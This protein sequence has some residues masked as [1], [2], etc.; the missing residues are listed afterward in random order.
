MRFKLLE[1]PQLITTCL[2]IL[3]EIFCEISI[4]Q[5]VE[6]VVNLSHI[7]GQSLLCGYC[8]NINLLSRGSQCFREVQVKNEITDNIVVTL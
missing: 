8:T 1:P 7:F 6:I 3:V 5:Q 4:L 2:L